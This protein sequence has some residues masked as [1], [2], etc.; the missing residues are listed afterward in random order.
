REAALGIAERFRHSEAID[1][2]FG[3][4]SSHYQDELREMSRRSDDV[5]VFNRLAAAVLFTNAQLRLPYAV[6]ANRLGQSGLWPHSISGDFPIVLVHVAATEEELLVRQLL[7]WHT[8]ARRRG[9]VSDLVILDQRTDEAAERLRTELS[10][11]IGVGEMLGKPGGVFLLGAAEVSAADA[12]LIAAAARAVFGAGRGS[13]T[14]Q[15]DLSY[16]A[17]PPLPPQLAAGPRAA[18]PAAQPAGPPEGLSFWNG[19]GGFTQDG[20]EYAI[21]IDGA[22]TGGPALP[23]APWTNVLANPGFGCLVTEAGLG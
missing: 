9:L 14:A 17:A 6:A 11:T 12:L 21:L 7:Q 8:F 2:A 3:G 5:V 20:R 19:I 18:E 1:S 22:A 23:P 4:A 13:L 10:Q 15:L 16:P